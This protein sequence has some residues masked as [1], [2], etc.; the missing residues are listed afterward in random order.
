MPQLLTQ[1]VS[2]QTSKTVRLQIG[3]LAGFIPE[4]WPASNRNTRPD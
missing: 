1:A 4:C 2:L 3:T